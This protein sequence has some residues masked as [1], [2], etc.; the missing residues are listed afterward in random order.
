MIETNITIGNLGD[1]LWM[2][3]LFKNNRDGIIN[4]LDV[5]ETRR[6]E[7]IF[8]KLNISIQYLPHLKPLTIDKTQTHVAQQYLNFFNINDDNCIPKI[9]IKEDDLLWAKDLI[10]KY[11]N[12]LVVISNNIGS[13]DPQNY[14]GAYR[15]PPLDIFKNLL[16]EY[17]KKYTLLHFGLSKNFIKKSYGNECNNFSELPNCINILDLNLS[18]LAACYSLIG[19][20]LGGDTGDYHLMLSVGGKCNVLI[21]EHHYLGYNYN[22]L[23]YF[24]SLWKNEKP[25][26][27]YTRFSQFADSLK[28]I[29]FDY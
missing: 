20:Y 3:P 5:S 19:K 18:K 15:T 4:I 28:N 10:S 6:L 17:S 2:T 23:L 8:Y 16:E 24:N 27:K 11:P 14:W 12:P 21:P 26:V 29:D 25:R 7:D 1:A 13:S 22:S 9:N